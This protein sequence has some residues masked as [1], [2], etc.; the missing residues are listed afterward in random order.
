MLDYEG[1][2]RHLFHAM[3]DAMS[4]AELS[5]YHLILGVGKKVS[6]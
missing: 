2:A 5:E 4:S 1:K 6:Q 3:C